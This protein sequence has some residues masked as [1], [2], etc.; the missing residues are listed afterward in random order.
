MTDA[1]FFQL[2]NCLSYRNDSIVCVHA[3][4]KDRPC[5]HSVHSYLAVAIMSS[6]VSPLLMQFVIMR[7]ATHVDLCIF[8]LAAR[9]QRWGRVRGALDRQL[10]ATVADVAA[11]RRDLVP[12]QVAWCHC[13][14]IWHDWRALLWSSPRR[15]LGRVPQLLHASLRRRRFRR[16]PTLIGTRNTLRRC[17]ALPITRQI[18]SVAQLHQTSSVV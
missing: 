7:R 5:Q 1:E 2:F 17:L 10:A 6:L 8:G 9:R 12:V 15:R 16:K 3:W 14:N 18:T 4:V 13:R 11:R